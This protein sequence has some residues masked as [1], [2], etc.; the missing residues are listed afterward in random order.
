MVFFKAYF[1]I[2]F[3]KGNLCM[4]I[5]Q[6]DNRRMIGREI[7][8]CLLDLGDGCYLSSDPVDLHLCQRDFGRRKT[9]CSIAWSRWVMTYGLPLRTRGSY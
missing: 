1:Y 4:F 9:H 3:T 5:F 2:G 6:E 8:M 7:S